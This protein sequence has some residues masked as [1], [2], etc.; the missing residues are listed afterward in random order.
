MIKWNNETA[1]LISS[2]SLSMTSILIIMN[3]IRKINPLDGF[4][5]KNSWILTHAEVAVIGKEKTIEWGYD[6]SPQFYNLIMLIH[7]GQAT[8][9]LSE[10]V[11]RMISAKMAQE[12]WTK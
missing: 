11:A 6:S 12:I 8:L 1:Y 9:G 2:K 10:A 7:G 3:I 4:E 5:E